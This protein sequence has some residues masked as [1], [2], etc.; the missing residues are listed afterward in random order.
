[1]AINALTFHRKAPHEAA[2]VPPY[3][4]GDDSPWRCAGIRPIIRR[5]IK[6]APLSA[7]RRQKLRF[8]VT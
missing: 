4:G 7:C 6:C 5:L 8:L 3:R 1:M 2:I